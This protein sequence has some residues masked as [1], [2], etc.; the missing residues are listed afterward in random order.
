MSEPETWTRVE[1]SVYMPTS[2]SRTFFVRTDDRWAAVARA[3][4][5][6]TARELECFNYAS[7]RLCGAPTGAVLAED[8][9]VAIEMPG[10]FEDN[11][12]RFN[13]LSGWRE[14]SK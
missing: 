1:I 10:R 9:A 4:A 14:K 6:M 11:P 13:S 7:A 5:E 12:S 3:I 2:W 8:K